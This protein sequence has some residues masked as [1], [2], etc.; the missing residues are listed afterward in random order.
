MIKKP[1]ELNKLKIPQSLPLLEGLCWNIKNPYSLSPQEM[2][3]IYE[4]R[5]RFLNVLGSPSDEEIKYIKAIGQ[6]FR[7][8]P[9]IMGEQSKQDIFD[10][11]NFVIEQLDRELFKKQQIVLGGGALIALKHQQL[12]YSSDLD[13]LTNPQNFRELKLK[14]Q[15]GETIFNRTDNIEVKQPRIDKYAIRYPLFVKQ[16]SKEIPLK[17]EIIADYDLP[18]GEPEDYNGFPCLNLIDRITAK[19]LA[20]TDRW[21]DGSK[22]SR[23]LIDLAIIA[24]SQKSLPEEALDKSKLI[25]RNAGSALQES[26]IKFQ[27]YPD[28]R[29]KCYDNLQITQPKLIVDGIDYLAKKCSLELTQR[30]FK[31]T[32]FSYLDSD[33]TP[34]R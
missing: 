16:G 5:W 14:L 19:L 10:S 18:I 33:E 8:L 4:E 31:E 17:L 21:A 20:N 26:L 9:L 30:T 7:G 22:F 27:S 28:H 29:E 34:H 25:Y 3:G 12:R 11:I 24:N 13:F 15:S 2:L 32:D 6:E 1:N 23:D